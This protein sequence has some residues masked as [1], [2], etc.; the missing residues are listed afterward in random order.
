LPC[1]SI[2]TTLIYSFSV[3]NAIKTQVNLVNKNECH[4]KLE[5]LNL[6]VVKDLR[7]D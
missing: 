1:K 7:G 6:F 4:L 3:V 5:I 2:D